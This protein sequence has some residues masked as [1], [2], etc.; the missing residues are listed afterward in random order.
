MRTVCVRGHDLTD[1]ANVKASGPGAC[2]ACH[3]LSAWC[4]NRGLPMPPKTHCRRGHLLEVGN[5]YVVPSTGA[6]Q[7]RACADAAKRTYYARNRKRLLDYKVELGRR[8][9]SNSAVVERERAQA[10]AERERLRGTATAAYGGK[11]ARCGRPGRLSF[12]SDDSL[13]LDHPDGDGAEHR[14]SI[15]SR[16]M[17][18]A[19]FYR[20]LEKSGWPPVVQLL[21]E[22][23][24]KTK[25]ANELR[26]RESA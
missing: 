8:R 2:A 19:R 6:V 25:T 13:H 10:A 22:P 11:C 24:H 9:R 17:A 26:R 18:G 12:G 23:C 1:P 14:L 21:C 16:K 3:R 4:R 15:G 20:W 7:C 5:V